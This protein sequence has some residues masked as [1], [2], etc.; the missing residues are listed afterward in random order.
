[1]HHNNQTRDGVYVDGALT[2]TAAAGMHLDASFANTAITGPVYAQPLYLAAGGTTTD[3]LIIVATAA[4]HVYALKASDGTQA[5][6]TGNPSGTSTQTQPGTPV[7]TGLCGRPL[8]PLG[9]TG[10]P[11]IDGAT[12]T[13][14]LDAMTQTT[15]NG[16][17]HMIHALNLDNKG[18][19]VAGW[20]V[21]VSM[22][23]VSA[24]GTAF[25]S[26]NQNQRAALAL[27]GGRVFVPYGG[28]IGDCN[29]YHGWIVGVSTTNPTDVKAWATRAFAGGIWGTSGIASDGTSVY[30]VTGNTEGTAGS[31]SSPGTYGDGESIF[32]LPTSLTPVA[33]ASTTDYWAP[34]NWSNLDGGDTDVGGTGIV[35]FSLAGST[36]SNLIMALGKDGNAYL[37]NRDGLGGMDAAPL[38]PTLKVKNGT[39]I[40]ASVAYTTTSGTYVAFAGSG[41]GCPGQA[42]GI[43]AIKVTPGSPPSLSVGWCGGTA[44]T[45]APAVSMTT[46][47]GANAI[48]WYVGSDNVLHGIDGTNGKNVY[49]GTTTMA[50]VKAHQTPIVANG[51]VFVASDS[52]IYAYTP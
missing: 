17:R 15:S 22:T 4:N 8:N 3:D 24:G 41:V 2:A 51:R 35:L 16:A 52:R 18:A 43:T 36:P 30:F 32:K 6:V 46:A 44:A 5:W 14:Y 50:N 42:G 23:A 34:S 29:N 47:Q 40:T 39:I 27:V 28:H 38:V 1:M 10:T 49:T 13:L 33:A 11:V 26:P 12:R 19:E 21:D 20:P 45:N 31:I 9:I 7:T 37:F 25:Q 48:L